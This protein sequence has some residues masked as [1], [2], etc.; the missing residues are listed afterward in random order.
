MTHQTLAADY[1]LPEPGAVIAGT[2]RA[3]LSGGP[4]QHRYAVDGSLQAEFRLAGPAEVRDAVAAAR[5]ALPGWRATPPARRRDLLFR[6]TEL[7][8]RDRDHLIWIGA[9]EIGTP[10]AAL[11]AI[12]GK[13]HAWTRYAAGWADKLE[14]R[15][16][17]SFQDD[18]VFDYTLC[19]PFGVI[20]MILTWNGPLMALAMKLGPALATGNT[21]VLKPPEISP[22]TVLHVMRLIDEAGFPPGVVNLVVGGAEAG[23]ALVRDPGVDKIAFTGGPATA[24]RIAAAL[25]PLLKP[26]IYELGGKSANLIFADADL[27]VAVRHAARQPLFLS[28]Q[29][30]VLPTRI[31]VE[32][33]IADTFTERVAATVAGLRLG[34]PLD[35]AT[36]LGPVIHRTAQA[37]LLDT[38]AGARARGDGRLRLGGGVPQGVAPEG[39]W[40]E[41]TIFD[42]VDPASPLAQ[43]ECF[44]PVIGIIPFDTED[45]AVAIANGTEFGL[46]AYVHTGN[47]TRAH[48]LASR[49]VAGTVQINGAPTARENAPFG[50]LGLSGYGREGG[51]DGLQEYIRVKNVAVNLI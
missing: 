11:Q 8:E 43:H 9:R 18:T 34:D 1:R 2:W 6:L 15:V 46:G 39:A 3:D 38:I 12:P 5:A 33:R 48:R 27:D 41:P 25:A 31:L 30:C 44:G 51:R 22:F 32:R 10:V 40:V 13:F 45:Q 35:P 21:L 20:G 28:G 16:V 7:V 47:V 42:N 49:L 14:G 26:A 17:S 50:G 4:A 19:E 36:E 37:R 29:G 23:E 24:Q